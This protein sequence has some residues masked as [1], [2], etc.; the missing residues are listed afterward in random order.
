M[1]PDETIE[2]YKRLAD[3]M[4]D[5]EQRIVKELLTDREAL[6]EIIDQLMGGKRTTVK[7]ESNDVR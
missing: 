3:F 7:K 2:R 4:P 1:I 5:T 6:L